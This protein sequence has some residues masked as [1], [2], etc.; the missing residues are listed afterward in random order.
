[1]FIPEIGTII[2][3]AENWTFKIIN[4]HRN[5]GLAKLLHSPDAND[6]Y[7]PWGTEASNDIGAGYNFQRVPKEAGNHTLPTGT[8]LEVDRIYIRK[9]NEEFSSVT[10]KMHVGAKVVRFFAKLDDV[11]R[12]EL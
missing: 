7:R 12:I 11:N 3:L 1:M 4:E 6:Y 8:S 5:Q 9:G 10:F 2:T